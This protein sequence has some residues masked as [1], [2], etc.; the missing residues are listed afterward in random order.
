MTTP[1]QTFDFHLLGSSCTLIRQRIQ[2][3]MLVGISTP[4]PEPHTQPNSRKRLSNLL[5]LFLLSGIFAADDCNAYVSCHYV[6]HNSGPRQ[7][8]AWTFRDFTYQPHNTCPYAGPPGWSDWMGNYI[9]IPNMNPGDSTSTDNI[10]YDS[11]HMCPAPGVAVQNPANMSYTVVNSKDRVD[12]YIDGTGVPDNDRPP[13]RD[14]S[15]CN[16]CGGM[17]VWSVSEP[18][19]SLWIQDEP[20]GYQPAVGPRISLT[21][22]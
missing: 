7:I 6:L 9:S 3:P 14:S 12:V 15:G 16:Q 2:S 18:Y 5:I 21:L 4:P 20:F 13:C 19:L 10:G 11:D 1:S 22:G 8:G 17:P